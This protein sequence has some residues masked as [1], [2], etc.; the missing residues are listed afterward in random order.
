MEETL[1]SDRSS[2]VVLRRKFFLRILKRPFDL[3]LSFIGLLL[4]TPLWILITLAI[5]FE[6]GGPVFFS[7]ERVGQGK[8]RFKILK[9]RSMVRDAERETGPVW[10]SDNDHRVTR[11]GRLLRATAMDELP[12]VW[13]ILRGDISFVGPRAERPEFVEKFREEIPNYDLRH[14]VRP[15]LTGLAQVYGRYDSD[16]REKLRYDILYIMK[17]SLWLDLRLIGLSFWITLRG[18]W[19]SRSKKF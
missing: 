7:Q 4:S 16:P 1:T 14:T 8:R 10:A 13:N 18:K 19:E 15:G 11:V 17:Q 5:K 3:I 12:Q 2:N 9:F 6:D